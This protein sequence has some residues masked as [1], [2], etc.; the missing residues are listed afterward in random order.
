LQTLTIPN[1]KVVIDSIGTA[2]PSVSGLLSESFQLPQELVLKLLYTAPSVLLED[3]TP[4]LAEQTSG[5]LEKLGLEVSL[6]DKTEK[7]SK[8]TTLFDISV[9]IDE[10]EK[11]PIVI[12]QLC[13]FL[14]CDEKEATGLLL[15]VPSI[16]L[17]GVS[18]STANAFS[19]RIDANVI[20]SDPKQDLYMLEVTDI[21]A[22]GKRQLEELLKTK[23]ENDFVYDI[24][25]K[26]A[27]RIWAGFQSNK[28]INITNQSHQRFE[29]IVDKATDHP[30]QERIFTEEVGMPK[31]IIGEV[32]DNLPIQLFSSLDKLEVY[33]KRERYA[34]SG[35]TCSVNPILYKEYILE[36]DTL[37]YK[38]EIIKLLSN[39]FPEKDLPVNGKHWVSP[40]AL[41]M[42]ITDYIAFHLE[43][44]DCEYE[45]K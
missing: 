14:G 32:L 34:L 25:Y 43:R 30:D 10:I 18:E 17:G 35:L 23:L 39:F 31:G 45:V 29:L 7:L 12:K 13:E 3:V 19:K 15:Q 8:N 20:I 4:E 2:S 26:T 44:L 9:H 37:E 36:L 40:Y 41:P 42:V 5:L 27:Q 33:E 1:Q 28:H 22:L 24:D 38:A 11:L 21:D 16:I 6:K